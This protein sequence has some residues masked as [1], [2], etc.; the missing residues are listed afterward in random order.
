VPVEWDDLRQQLQKLTATLQP[1]QPG[2]VAPLGSFINT[3]ADNLR[4]NGATIRDT[5]TKLSQATAAL[6]D[7]STDIFSTVRNLALLV[8]ALQGS[9]GLMS[10]LNRNLATVTGLLKNSPDEVGRAVT[11]LSQASDDL[12][13]LLA[14]NREPI[15]VTV[16][17]L[18]SI[19]SAINESSYDLKQV[20]HVAPTVLANYANVYNP[21][22]DAF[23]GILALN[24]MSDPITFICGAIQAASR[25]GAEQSAKLCVQYLAPIVKN[26][27]YNWLP[28]GANLVVGARAPQRNHL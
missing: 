11:T 18:S 16:D 19:T 28:L 15:G 27:Q 2:G 20:L 7:H 21:A 12:A 13:T 22:Q 17:K 1:T 5:L 25:L 3:A 6:G 8:S 9:S 26:R 10:D 14:Q 4:G 23:T 24:N